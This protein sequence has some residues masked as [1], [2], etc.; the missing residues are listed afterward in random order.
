MAPR[1]EWGSERP[2]PAQVTR[3]Q[4]AEPA[5]WSPPGTVANEAL[6]GTPGEEGRGS[7][8]ATPR[9]GAR[10]GQ[11]AALAGCTLHGPPPTPPG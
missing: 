2:T 11:G 7:G 1:R 5:V 6:V 10:P 8:L 9:A 4:R 3:E